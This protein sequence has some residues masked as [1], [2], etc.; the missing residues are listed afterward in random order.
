MVDV[1]E[2]YVH[3]YAGRSKN[4]LSASLGVD[5][6]T[7]RKYL[8]PAEAAGMTPGGAV[9][10]EADWAPLIK[11]WFPELADRRLRQVTWPEIDKHRDYIK[12]LLGTV[13]VSTIH[14]RLRD[15]HGLTVSV[16]SL[17]RWIAAT[18]PRGFSACGRSTATH[19]WRPP[20]PGPSRSVTRPIARSRASSSPAPRA[21][22]FP[23][24]PVTAGPRP[25]SMDLGGSSPPPRPPT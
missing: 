7:I 21:S 20:A 25:S 6:K 11:G 13:T 9:M 5:R 19:G 16:S 17:R 2:I 10:T 3:W 15:E 12:G 14:Q 1:T 24:L 22:L 23:R 4:E 8:A 18:L